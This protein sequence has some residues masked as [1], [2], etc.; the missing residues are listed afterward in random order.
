MAS[1][2]ASSAAD[3]QANAANQATASQKA[4]FDKTV[5][6]E[7]PYNMAGQGAMNKLAFLLGISPN[8]YSSSDPNATIGPNGVVS[9][10]SASAAP[11]A[12]VETADQ[13]RAR[14]APQYSQSGSAPQLDS[15]LL[16]LLPD[17]RQ[18]AIYQASNPQL[19]AAV[20]QELARQQATPQATGMGQIGS[21]GLP[22][23]GTSDPAYGSL[24]HNF[25]LS[26]FQLDPGIQ[27]QLK[28]G[29]QALQNSQAAKDGVL[30]GAALKG[31]IG[32]N[33]DYAG[34]GYQSAFDRYNANRSFTLGSLMDMTKLG[35]SA[36]SNTVNNASGFS[37]GIANTIT[38]A[39]NALAAGQVGSANALS[40]GISGAG[41]AY[42]L[43]NMLGGGG[44]ATGANTMTVDPTMSYLYG[45]GGIGD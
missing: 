29:G 18:N 1:D 11:A 22:A 27:F 40:S 36:A 30:S 15:S 28:Y 7:N 12:P 6:L 26:D 21:N 9:Q 33:Q 42:F 39:G 8:G 43:R 37:S 2:A 41:N 23:G 44:S 31:L 45:T 20:Q 3:T 25:D 13:I 5:Q 10:A 38:G 35:Q 19:E 14:L 24:L 16:K 17:D 4:M 34:Q 32:F